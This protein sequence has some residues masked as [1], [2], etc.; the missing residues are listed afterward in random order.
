VEVQIMT[1]DQRIQELVAV[2]AAITANCHPCLQYHVSKA[3]ES[4]AGAEEIADAVAV[5]KMVRKGAASKTDQFAA[6]LISTLAPAATAA[7]DGCGCSS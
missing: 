6:S 1:L 7:E 2:G 5:G 3:V 4:G